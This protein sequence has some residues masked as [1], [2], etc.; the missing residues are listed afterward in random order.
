[1]IKLSAKERRDLAEYQRN[2][3]TIERPD[4]KGV[5]K[6]TFKDKQLAEALMYLR[7]QIKLAAKAGGTRGPG[8]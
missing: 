6:P 5:K 1:V 3:E 2:L 7:G 4:K 8:G